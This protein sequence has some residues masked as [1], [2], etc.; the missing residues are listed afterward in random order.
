MDSGV[1]PVSLGEKQV[2]LSWVEQRLT[3]EGLSVRHALRQGLAPGLGQQQQADD[4]QQ[5][6]AGEDHVVQEVAFL[7]VELHDGRSEHAEAGAG[8]D[9]AKSA[10]PAQREDLLLR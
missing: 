2:L 9:Q 6:A 4:A 10:T 5:G 3:G 7:V 1:V 8:Q